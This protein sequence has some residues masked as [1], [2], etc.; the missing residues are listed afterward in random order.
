MVFL[1]FELPVRFGVYDFL[2]PLCC[3]CSYGFIAQSK[4]TVKAIILESSR[5]NLM[6][7]QLLEHHQG[8][9]QSQKLSS[10]NHNCS[11]RK[12]IVSANFLFF[13]KGRFI[14]LLIK[15]V[16]FTHMTSSNGIWNSPPSSS[17]FPL[18][19]RRNFIS[20]FK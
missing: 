13:H 18:L 5:Y 3:Q 7:V 17:G 8:S 2:L 9:F 11:Y 15:L 20:C 14:K 16:I 19:S 6:A 10:N 4:E 1:L 12:K